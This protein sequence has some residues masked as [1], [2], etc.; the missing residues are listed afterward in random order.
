MRSYLNK[1]LVFSLLLQLGCI[2]FLYVLYC[3]YVEEN[4]RLWVRIAIQK[5]RADKLEMAIKSMCPECRT[6]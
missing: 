3:D 2:V 5:D 4:K 1:L 6:R